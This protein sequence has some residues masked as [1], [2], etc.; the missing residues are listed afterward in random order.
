MLEEPGGTVN[1]FW[2]LH[3]LDWLSELSDAETAD[4]QKQ[5]ARR[6]YARAEMVFSPSVHPDSVYLLEKGLVRIYR[7]APSGAE[8]TFGFVS[9]GEIFGELAAFS[10][11]PRESYAQAVRPSVVLQM[12]R[13][14][15]QR[16]LAA[17]PSIGL[18]ITKQIGSRLKRIESRVENLVFRDVRWR[19]ARI[20]LDLAED[21]GREHGRG[22]LIDLTLSQEE[23]ATLVG[24]TRQSVNASLRDFEREGLLTRERRRFVLTRPADLRRTVTE[25]PAAPG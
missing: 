4:L 17:H 14:T 2:H 11:R 8:T 1:D 9:P 22:V 25:Q 23:L 20:L 19:V 5:S 6:D 12:S 7:L 13:E 21:F 24:A 3:N 18:E 10:D 15:M 16:V